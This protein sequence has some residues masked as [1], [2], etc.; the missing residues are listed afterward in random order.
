M[1]IY[2]YMCIYIYIYIY[3]YMHIYIYMYIS[4]YIYIHFPSALR[5]LPDA[6]FDLDLL[7]VAR[8]LAPAVHLGACVYI[9]ISI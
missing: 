7:H 8:V 6:K 4:I 1:H 9:H 3:I 2:N 5:R